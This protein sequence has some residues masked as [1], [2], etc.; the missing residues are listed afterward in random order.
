MAKYKCPTLGDCDKANAG[1]IFERAAGEDIKCP[2]CN[3]MMEKIETSGTTGTGTGPGGLNKGLIIGGL[4][5]VA[6]LA[7]GGYFFMAKSDKS[8][9]MAPVASAPIEA[10][11]PIP[12]SAP[13]PAAN[14]AG[15]GISPSEADTKALR[16][17]GQEK[18]TSGDASGA[19]QASAKAAANEM[20]KLAIAKMAQGKLE[21]AEK[22]LA[23]ARTR[24]PRQ[25]LVYYNT[26]ILRLKQSRQDDA[27]K[28]LEASFLAGFSYFD[29]MDQDT[30]LD[31]LRKNP[32]FAE[33]VAKY[34]PAGK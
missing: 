4:V 6:A 18:L 22:D 23:E 33:L 31:G 17:Q 16:Q 21:E 19:E 25:S 11:K 7:G 14:A 5:A 1:E 26:A 24:D 8:A 20:I 2:S 30:D 9:E 3:T 15:S 29:K 34:R 32:R 13:A 28:E 12:V 10:A 27:L